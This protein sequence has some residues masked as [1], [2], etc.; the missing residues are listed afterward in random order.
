MAR[1]VGAAGMLPAW[2]S[3]RVVG[4]LLVGALVVHVALFEWTVLKQHLQHERP[5]PQ[6]MSAYFHGSSYPL[7]NDRFHVLVTV[8]SNPNIN[9]E[10][11]IATH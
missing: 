2:L 9:K 6:H 10:K 3:T 11:I 4:V 1:Q 5:N 8:S 7:A